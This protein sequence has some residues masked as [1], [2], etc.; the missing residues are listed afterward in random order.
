[1]KNK[2]IVFTITFLLLL[3]GIVIS[4]GSEAREVESVVGEGLGTKAVQEVR[5]W[6]DLN[7]VREDLSGDY[8]LL[9]D[10]DEDTEGYMDYNDPDTAGWDPIGEVTDFGGFTGIFD[11]NGYEIS[12]LYIDRPDTDYVGLFAAIGRPVG[13]ELK[14]LGLIDVD[15]TG[16]NN[17]GSIAGRIDCDNDYT[18][19][20]IRNSFTSGSIVGERYVGGLVGYNMGNS[21]ATSPVDGIYD[22]YS[23]AE[24]KGDSYVGGLIGRHGHSWWGTGEL[25]GSYFAGS[26]SGDEY[27]GGLVGRATD[28]ERT[29]PSI[30]GSYW[31]EE[32]TGV[33][34]GIGLNEPDIFEGE[35]RTTE[36]MTWEYDN[37]YDG[38]DFNDTW[39]DGDH[40]L[41]VDTQGNSGYPSL[42]WQDE[43]DVYNLEIYVYGQGSTDPAVGSHSYIENTEV[44]LTAEPG[45]DWYFKEWT[46]DH[47]G[48]EESI[49]VVMDSDKEITAHFE[50]YFTLSI[51]GITGDGTV[52]VDGDVVET[53]FEKNYEQG[54][55]AEML[56]DP[57]EGWYFEGWGGINEEDASITITLSENVTITEVLF[58]EDEGFIS[59]WM[60]IGLILVIVV[61]LAIVIVYVMMGDDDDTNMEPVGDGQ[62]QLQAGHAQTQ[63]FQQGHPPPPQQANICPDCGWPIRFVEEYDSW[64]CDDCQEYK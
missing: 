48:T 44:I 6:H 3:S 1:M 10:L 42:R 28:G 24:I 23:I 52:I 56:A 58:E 32:V 60:L 9:N 21:D 4:I 31:N 25:V 39:R 7:D 27:V 30:V 43:V 18:D 22:S 17:T 38:W 55:E 12:G 37:T 51:E 19:G 14:N 15:I 59:T 36:E 50:N 40:E 11:G 26:L 45:E 41:V 63:Q 2:M 57:D 20:L 34:E 53:P 35:G 61:V 5:D 29:N 46:G 49:T 13:G 64:F 47:E 62:Q 54:E 16:G 33:S 8:I